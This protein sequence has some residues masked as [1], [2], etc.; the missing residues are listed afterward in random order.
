MELNC[1]IHF[2]QALAI[3]STEMETLAKTKEGV[4]KFNVI[5]NTV[6]K[7]IELRILNKM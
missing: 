7:A 4:V 5:I 3:W 2:D 6:G 1:L